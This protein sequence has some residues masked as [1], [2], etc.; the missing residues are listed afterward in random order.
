MATIQI[1]TSVVKLFV[2]KE[3]AT[4]SASSLQFGEALLT[5]D[6]RVDDSFTKGGNAASKWVDL[7]D[8]RLASFF[9]DEA[10]LESS[11]PE[12]TRD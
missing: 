3:G 8:P 6:G 4:T 1:P 10:R 11:L 7:K 9:K 5:S 12:L 2:Q